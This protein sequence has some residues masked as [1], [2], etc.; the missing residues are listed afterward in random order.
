MKRIEYRSLILILF[1]AFVWVSGIHC[2]AEPDAVSDSIGGVGLGS[3]LG[4]GASSGICQDDITWSDPQGLGCSSYKGLPCTGD[5][6]SNCPVS[7]G[8]CS[9][10]PGSNNTPTG[11]GTVTPCSEFQCQSGACITYAQFCNGTWDCPEGDDETACSGEGGGEG[12]TTEGGGEG[13]TTEGGGEGSTTEGGGEGSTTEGGEGTP[14]EFDCGD[15]YCIPL[16]WVCDGSPDCNEGEDEFNC[17]V[18]PVCDFKCSNG[19]CLSQAKVCNGFDEC[20]GGEDEADCGGSEGGACD[21]ICP[22]GDCLS[23]DK[24]C[25]GF[26]ECPGGEDEANCGESEGGGESTGCTE[27]LC[28]NSECIPLLWVC[29][30]TGDCNSSEDEENCDEPPEPSA[31]D[32]CVGHCGD[33]ADSGCWCDD[34]CSDLGDCCDD[35]C[36]ACP[37]TQNCI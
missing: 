33:K 34:G 30:G 5:A 16:Q 19:D 32:S 3:G 1:T 29:D 36:I 4:S 2:E 9:A 8:T 10:L 6:A 23:A 28:N 11:G 18:T 35:I 24:L 27:F 20:L 21:Y 14:C 13:S 22:N 26:D 31:S 7:C 25:N 12:S 15:G 17:G 37:E